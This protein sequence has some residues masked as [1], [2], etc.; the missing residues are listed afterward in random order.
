L[1]AHSEFSANVE[2][3]GAKK[4]KNIQI[5]HRFLVIYWK[6]TFILGIRMI[7]R[8]CDLV[9]WRGA[10]EVSKRAKNHR[11]IHTQSDPYITNTSLRREK[12]A[13]YEWI[14]RPSRNSRYGG[15]HR[16]QRKRFLTGIAILVAIP[17][18][19]NCFFG[20]KLQKFF[21]TV[22]GVLIGAIIG[23]V[24]AV[25]SRDEAVMAVAMILVPILCGFIAYKLYRLG[26]FIHF[27][28]LGS[29]ASIVV[30]LVL[31]AGTVSIGAGVIIGLVIGVL[32]LALNKSFIIVTTAISGGMS[33]GE[34]IGLFMGDGAIGLV[35]GVLLSVAGAMVQF[36]M[37]KKKAA[38]NG[39]PSSGQMRKA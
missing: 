24:V 15:R 9:L 27:W 39:S 33:A 14:G 2:D 29:M 21:I 16:R 35:L 12:D 22:S 6:E 8:P 37:E 11:S 5:F 26:V 1:R 23:F 19:L 4:T 31:G 38:P 32:A 30:L 13:R 18:L 7:Y 10:R 25:I 28:L 3:F 20:Y 36:S 17:M 34:T